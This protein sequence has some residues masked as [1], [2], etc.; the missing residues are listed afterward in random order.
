VAGGGGAPARVGACVARARTRART[1][2]PLRNSA[3]ACALAAAPCRASA[4]CGVADAIARCR[5]AWMQEALQQWSA[6]LARAE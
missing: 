2:A 5:H 1:C 4:Q 3:D 6:G